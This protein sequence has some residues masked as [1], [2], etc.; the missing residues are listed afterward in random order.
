MAHSQAGYDGQLIFAWFTSHGKTPY[1][2]EQPVGSLTHFY[3]LKKTYKDLRRYKKVKYSK[4]SNL[5][6]TIKFKQVEN[7]VFKL[8]LE[9]K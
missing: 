8:E 5:S 3:I 4:F 1:K 9:Q 6:E 2:F 7:I